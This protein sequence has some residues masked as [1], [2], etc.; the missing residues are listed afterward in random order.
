[1]ARAA[2]R[3]MGSRHMQH[4]AAGDSGSR[5]AARGRRG[6]GDLMAASSHAID[7]G[8]IGRACADGG[9][10]RG[11]PHSRVDAPRNRRES[12]RSMALH[13]AV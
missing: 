1:M 7:D 10:V 13:R 5:T 9:G 3:S 12:I 4:S 8:E 6:A 11:A 2:A